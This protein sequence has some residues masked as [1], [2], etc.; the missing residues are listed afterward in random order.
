[1]KYTVTSTRCDEYEVG[2]CRTAISKLIDDLGGIEKF[3]SP[4]DKILLKLNLLAGHK[5]E[6]AATTNPVIVKAVVKIVQ[7]AGGIAYLGDSP[8][9]M[10]T[11]SAYQQIL[12]TTGIAEAAQ[13]TGANIVFFDGG[14]QNYT[15]KSARKFKQFPVVQ[16]AFDFDK[17]IA[18]PKLKTH[19]FTGLTC[20]VKLLYGYLPGITKAENHLHAGKNI[21]TF[22]ELLLDIYESFPPML[23]IADAIVAMQRNGPAHGEPV[24][25]NIL[26]ASTSAAA[27]DWAACRIT[28]M[29]PD[30]I[31]TVRL[32]GQREIGPK[33]DEDVEWIGMSPN[34]LHYKQFKPADA[35]S[36]TAFPAWFMSLSG[37]LFTPRP[38]ITAKCKSCGICF[39]HCPPHAMAMTPGKPPVI[40]YTKCIRCYCCQELCPHDAVKVLPPRVKLSMDFAESVIKIARKLKGKDKVK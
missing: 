35:M 36:T 25:I 16:A 4:G 27:I 11:E 33:C 40:D 22:S 21:D 31:A 19:Q 30:K 38:Q 17:V 24:S 26:F 29:P 15:S 7:A 5:P 2:K 23:T 10:V 20:G 12:E 39:K 18:L 14:Q 37:Y 28:G 1:M 8:G 6:L 9:G 3:V 32:A 13:E 34:E